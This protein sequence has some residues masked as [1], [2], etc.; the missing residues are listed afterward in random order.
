M[1]FSLSLAL[2][3]LTSVAGC[4]LVW[5]GCSAGYR[6]AYEGDLHFEHCYRLDEEARITVGQKRLCWEQWTRSYA[7]RQPHDRVEYAMVRQ[8]AL[9]VAENNGPGAVGT[10]PGGP[11][12]PGVLPDAKRR[13]PS[14]SSPPPA[15]G[16]PLPTPTSAFAPPPATLAID[17]G[18]GQASAALDLVS[19]RPPQLSSAPGA[20]CGSV[21]G[22]SW[23]ECER[24]CRIGGCR[25]FCDEGYRSF[26]KACF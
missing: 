15:P 25:S 10:G 20:S 22:N 8:Q 6:D 12:Q 7:R 13:A 17:G 1:R 19:R 26:M 2:R 24:S 5:T 23:I 4:C 11:S 3:V 14:R 18:S 9:A 21:C 16:N